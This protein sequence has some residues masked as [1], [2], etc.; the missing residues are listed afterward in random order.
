MTS[1]TGKVVLVTGATSGIG[2][3]SALMLADRGATVIAGARRGAQGESLVAE[4]K[5]KGGNVRFAAVDI[6]SEASVEALFDLIA[7]DYG[8]LDGALNNAGVEADAAPLADTP[9]ED[10]DRVFN[11][12]VKGTWLCMRREMRMMRDLGGGSIVNVAS[13]AGVSGMANASV[14]VASKHAIVGMTKSAALDHPDLGIRVNC[15]CPGATTTEMSARW[16]D[17][18]PGGEAALAGYVPMKRVAAASEQAE[19]ALFLLS[20]AASYMTGSI[21]LA[22]G[23]STA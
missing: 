22:D 11:T 16:S 21:V 2:R 7:R 13:M 18:L 10:F 19:V 12:N 9:T 1:F 4:A 17:R 23:G 8:R 15:L 3:A 6:A 5:A 20:D 14:Y